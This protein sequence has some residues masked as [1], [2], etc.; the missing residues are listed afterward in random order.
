MDDD[1]LL[2]E[3]KNTGFSPDQI[4]KMYENLTNTYD[5]LSRL[6]IGDFE[7]INIAVDDAILFMNDYISFKKDNLH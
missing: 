4:N 3:Y 1:N 7:S 5:L 6:L 2:K